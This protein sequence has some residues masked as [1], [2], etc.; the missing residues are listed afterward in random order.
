VRRV[1]G[2]GFGRIKIALL[3]LRFVFEIVF[4]YRSVNV[5]HAHQANQYAFA[6][7]VAARVLKKKFL[8][9][10][11]NSGERFDLKV[12]EKNFPAKTGKAMARYLARRAD[13]FVGINEGIRADL[14]R[15][16]VPSE[17]ILDIPNG[18][19]PP[20]DPWPAG[21]ERARDRLGWDAGEKVLVCVAGLKADKNHA[22]LLELAARVREK[23]P[24]RLVLAG[25][26]PERRAL[27]KRAREL[28]VK[29][30]M[31]IT[32]WTHDVENVLRASDAFVLPSGMEGISNALLE[33]MALGMP[34]AVSDVP[35]NRD[36]VSDG[37]SGIQLD[38]RNTAS[39]AQAVL[40]MLGD[41]KYARKLGAG[42][43][44]TVLLKFDLAG[45]AGRYAACYGTLTEG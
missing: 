25:D 29:D 24:V 27:E 11:G 42:A 17:R 40:R 34:C 18:V 13:R 23:E 19:M 1:R 36:L 2:A 4:R 37:V 39:A 3:A 28:G 32:G 21:K 7:L 10:C 5:I 15:W 8:V 41:S 14:K 12:L 33:A 38:F 30:A 9:K 43:R 45:V 44:D 22:L 26:G 35:G 6:A 20:R 31:T 16:G